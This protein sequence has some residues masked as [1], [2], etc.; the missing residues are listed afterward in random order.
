MKK[1]IT[2]MFCSGLILLS[3]AAAN[4]QNAQLESLQP[5]VSYSAWRVFSNASMQV[6]GAYYYAPGKQRTE[7]QIEGQAMTGIIREDLGLLWTLP[8]AQAQMNVYMEIPLDSSEARGSNS[9]LAGAQVVES[10]LLGSEDVG[11]YRTQ[12][13]QV[14]VHEPGSETFRGDVW[15]TEHMIP[16]RMEMN[17]ESGDRFV[18]EQRNIE[19][20][21]QADELFEVPAGYT[22]LT[23][24]GLRGALGEAFRGRPGGQGTDDGDSSGPGFAGEV[25]GEAA[26]AARQGVVDGVGQ[27]VRENVGRRI[28]GIFRRNQ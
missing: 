19:I 16:V 27:G 11:G 20:G 6:E 21:P 7:M 12:R 22:R 5:Q 1:L 8:P 24:G 28:R 14:T 25:A 23:L 10:R 4:A 2:V 9:S 17:D 15:V 13:Y 18:M 26:D 3:T